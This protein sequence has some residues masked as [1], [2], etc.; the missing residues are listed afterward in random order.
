MCCVKLRAIFFIARNNRS[1]VRFCEQKCVNLELPSV[2]QT[3]W[4]A[5]KYDNRIHLASLTQSS[6][7]ALLKHQLLYTRVNYPPSQSMRYMP[8]HQQK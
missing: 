1:C 6:W 2:G 4:E 5:I 3:W 7:Q 8:V